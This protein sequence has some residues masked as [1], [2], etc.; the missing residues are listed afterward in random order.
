MTIKERQEHFRHSNPYRNLIHAATK[1]AKIEVAKR[2]I[3]ETRHNILALQTAV[4]QRAPT[5][6]IVYSAFLE[7]AQLEQYRWLDILSELSQKAL[8]KDP[9][10]PVQRY[11]LNH[12]TIPLDEILR[13]PILSKSRKLVRS[14]SK[15]D[16]DCKTPFT[17]QPLKRSQSSPLGGEQF[18]FKEVFLAYGANVTYFFR[19]AYLTNPIALINNQATSITTEGMLGVK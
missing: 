3:M 14:Q 6:K 16:Q 1:P 13:T 7:Q 2:V 17:S 8:T 18:S 12:P 4:F 11:P 10:S 9:I 15:N 19:R 5:D